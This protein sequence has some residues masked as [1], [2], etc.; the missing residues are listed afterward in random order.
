MSDTVVESSPDDV[1]V[2]Q[3]R[4][5]DHNAW[6]L[7]TETHSRYLQ[8]VLVRNGADVA[9]AEDVVQDLWAR[10]HPDLGAESRLARFAPGKPL[11]P[12]LTT[13]ARNMLRD[14]QRRTRP[15]VSID[16]QNDGD[17]PGMEIADTGDAHTAVDDS[18]PI[19]EQAVRDAWLGLDPLQ[20]LILQLVFC[21]RVPQQKVALL[22]GVNQS[23]VSRDMMASVTAFREST[24]AHLAAADPAGDWSWA[25]IAESCDHLPGFDA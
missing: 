19:I 13:L 15:H 9:Q 3:C 24:L 8:N 7:L 23:S 16:A 2:A 25:D 22:L 14:Q 20:R 12:W 21:E 4:A 1:L 6:I 17:G 18:Q 10:C 11:R 5:G